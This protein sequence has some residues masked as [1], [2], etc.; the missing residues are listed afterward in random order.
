MT[1]VVLPTPPFWFVQAVTLTTSTPQRVQM[2]LHIL[3]V[4]ALAD[5]Y[6]RDCST[7]NLTVKQHAEPSSAWPNV[8]PGELPGGLALRPTFEIGTLIGLL[9]GEGHFGGDGRNPQITL[10]MHVR[11]ER[12]FRW[13]VEPSVA[14]RT[15]RITTRAQLLPVDGAWPLPARELVPLLDAYLAPGWM[16]TP[17]SAIRP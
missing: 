6:W 12:I 3:P 8:P 17:G 1:V 4:W 9:V 16:P 13:L 15:A 5:G 2:G 10:R 14:G 7:C 11:H